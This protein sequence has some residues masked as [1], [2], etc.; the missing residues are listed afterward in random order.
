MAAITGAEAEAVRHPHRVKVAV[1]A[2]SLIH[3]AAVTVDPIAGD[4][5][6]GTLSR[7]GSA[8]SRPFFLSQG[9]GESIL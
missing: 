6:L 4:K 1:V 8:S 2:G 3:P 7:G 5:S 9:A